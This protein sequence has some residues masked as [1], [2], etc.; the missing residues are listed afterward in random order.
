MRKDLIRPHPP[1]LPG[2][3]AFRFRHLLIRDAAYSRLP[4]AT[5]AE[6]HERYARW[7]E[8]AT[9]DFPELDE[10]AG[11]HLEQAVRNEQDLGRPSRRPVAERAAEHLSRRAG[12]R[13][14]AAT[15][16]RHGTCSSVPCRWRPTAIR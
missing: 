4:K 12:A 6:L 5:R 1:N 11:W 7:L 16:R 13:A 10:I 3:K 14:T 8:T 2:E 15:W 9:V